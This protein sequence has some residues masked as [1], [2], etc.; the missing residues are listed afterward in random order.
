VK[1][2]YVDTSC[3]VAAAFNEPGA[4][5]V[6]KRLAKFDRVLSSPL[7]EA[8]L[9]SALRREGRDLNERY[10]RAIELITVDRPLRAEIEQVLSVGYIRGADCWHL[11]TALYLAADP[12]ELSFV[13]LDL[14][15]RTAARK[16]GFP[17]P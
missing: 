8:E 2:A 7:L 10:I 13:T 1:I 4:T 9:Y 3:I 6:T 14:P 15:Q 12:S 11:A 16:L 17:T 5:A